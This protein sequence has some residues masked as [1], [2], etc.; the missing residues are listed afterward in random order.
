VSGGERPGGKAKLGAKG[1]EVEEV[2]GAAARVRIGSGTRRS[3]LDRDEK[4][5]VEKR[6]QFLGKGI[7]SSPGR[8]GASSLKQLTTSRG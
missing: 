3:G 2:C 1:G 6:V 7:P 4:Q 5:A 8:V